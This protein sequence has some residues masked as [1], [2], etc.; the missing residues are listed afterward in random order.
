M[1]VTITSEA[2]LR[3]HWDHTSEILYW[4]T[5]ASWGWHTRDVDVS[6]GTDMTW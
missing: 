3:L 6:T 1:K 5:K 2:F 4:I